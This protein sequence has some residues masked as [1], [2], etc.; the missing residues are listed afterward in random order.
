MQV[1][2]RWV[3]VVLGD[4]GPSREQVRL[5]VGMSLDLLATLVVIA[6]AVAAAVAFQVLAR[7]GRDTGGRRGL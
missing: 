3:A 4:A 7:V 1:I 5:R 2:K 6:L